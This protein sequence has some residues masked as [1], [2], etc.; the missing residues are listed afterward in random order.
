MRNTRIQIVLVLAALIA[1]LVSGCTKTSSTTTKPTTAT[2]ATT[3]QPTTAAKQTTAASSTAVAT[4][5]TAATTTTRTLKPLPSLIRMS[6]RPGT[7]GGNS[8]LAFTDTLTKQLGVKV[9]METAASELETVAAMRAGQADISVL[10]GSTLTA[11]ILGTGDFARPEWGPQPLR[12]ITAGGS[13]IVV[14]FTTKKSGIKTYADVKGARVAFYPNSATRNDTTAQFLEAM[15]LTW[16]DV[17]KVNVDAPEQMVQAVTDGIIDVGMTSIG[18]ALIQLDA[19]AG[20]YV[21]PFKPTPE[22]EKAMYEKTPWFVPHTY[23]PGELIG[24]TE[25]M[26]LPSTPQYL[27]T[28][29][30]MDDDLAYRLAKA[31]YEVVEDT[32]VLKDA[33]WTKKDAAFIPAVPP[34]HPGAIRF[35]KE[36]GLWGSAHD[37]FQQDAIQAEQQ[38]LA[39]WKAKQG[40]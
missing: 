16:N 35:Y 12:T 36:I 7:G 30:T 10:G 9:S 34:Y 1:V 31:A 4:S 18:A 24:V 2:Q 11:P 19:T 25:T 39:A 15:G 22:R 13:T 21:I 6:G 32:K 8:A 37:K 27:V 20:L 3:A 14:V 26:T 33:G 38:R 5:S 28:M 40:K 29:S 23:K 17:K